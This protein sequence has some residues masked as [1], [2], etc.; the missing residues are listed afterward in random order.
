MKFLT[1]TSKVTKT[2]KNIL[3]IYE[4]QWP[5]KIKYFSMDSKRSIIWICRD[6][7]D[8]KNTWCTTLQNIWSNTSEKG[9]QYFC[10]CQ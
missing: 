10:P 9:G 5:Y 7:Q 4:N 2:R 3:N 1:S 6:F 8:T